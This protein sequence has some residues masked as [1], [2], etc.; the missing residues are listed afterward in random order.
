[1]ALKAL[2]V[3]VL[4]HISHRIDLKSAC[5]VH[6]NRRK[7][8][9]AAVEFRRTKYSRATRRYSLLRSRKSDTALSALRHMRARHV[10]SLAVVGSTN[11]VRRN[12]VF[13]RFLNF[14]FLKWQ[15]NSGFSVSFSLVFRSRQ[16]SWGFPEAVSLWSGIANNPTCTMYL[17][18]WICKGTQMMR[19]CIPWFLLYCFRTE[20]AHLKCPKMENG[21]FSHVFSLNATTFSVFTHTRERDKCC[22]YCMLLFL[23]L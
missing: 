6:L 20:T 10:V 11:F 9:K 4:Y 13:G 1:M 3:F 23:L 18:H 17:Y 14:S 7:T 2:I 12:F 22:I 21:N 8:L 19:T 16:R 15:G 5:A